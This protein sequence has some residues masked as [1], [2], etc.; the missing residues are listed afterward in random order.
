MW[1][2]GMTTN[3]KFISLIYN[4]TNIPQANKK[5]EEKARQTK[6]IIVYIDIYRSR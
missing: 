6:T 1:E 5:G 4:D 2:E 3:P